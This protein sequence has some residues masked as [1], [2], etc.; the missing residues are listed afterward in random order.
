MSIEFA[1]TLLQNTAEAFQ[2]ISP[3]VQP[4]I[5]KAGEVLQSLDTT[6]II[7]Y[8]EWL[9]GL[10]R[11]ISIELNIPLGDAVNQISA[12]STQS[13]N[14]SQL[15]AG[16]TL[17]MPDNFV[18]ILQTLRD[19]GQLTTTCPD[20]LFNVPKGVDWQWLSQMTGIDIPTLMGNNLQITTLSPGQCL[21]I[22]GID[23]SSLNPGNLA[24]I[25][26]DFAATPTLIQGAAET[27]GLASEG[28]EI[29]PWLLGAV[30]VVGAG[31]LALGGAFKRNK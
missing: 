27:A 14:L 12:L 11:T 1:G 8:G 10:A 29:W 23:P 28:G 16:D 25:Q 20:N 15:F 24:V 13:G 2:H 21:D 18:T 5:A 22:G 30:A 26:T 6:W 31:A 9:Y 19:S 3:F 4:L 7:N 17:S